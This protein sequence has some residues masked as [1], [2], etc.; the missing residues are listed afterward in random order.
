MGSTGG[1]A[2]QEKRIRNMN[3]DLTGIGETLLTEYNTTSVHLWKLHR[4]I[5]IGD[6]LCDKFPIENVSLSG[7]PTPSF[8]S[9][10]ESLSPLPTPFGDSDS[11]VEEIDILLS[12]SNDSL[13]DYE[14]FRFDIKEKSSG[15][16]TSHSYH[17]PSIIRI[18]TVLMS[19][20]LKE[21]N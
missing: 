16:T 1:N 20:I 17:S 11:L 9:V 6:S 14:T 10:V 12:H 2:F 19:I 4:S 18:H 3:R 7:N 8:D 21:K 15:S 5:D 13:P